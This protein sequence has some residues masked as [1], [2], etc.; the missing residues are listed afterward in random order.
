M[1][2]SLLDSGVLLDE[3][4]VYL[5]VA[6][7]TLRIFDVF[8]AVNVG[9]LNVQSVNEALK[10]MRVHACVRECGERLARL[11]KAFVSTDRFLL[12]YFLVIENIMNSI[13]T[14]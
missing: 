8:S 1:F 14:Y 2:P 4:N 5:I 13:Q 12:I 7:L 11:G 9:L 6:P 10:C 3:I